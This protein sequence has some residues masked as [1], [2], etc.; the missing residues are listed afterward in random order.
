MVQDTPP[1]NG[2]S[3]EPKHLRL[4]L[5]TL[6]AYLDDVLEPAQAREIGTKIQETQYASQLVERIQDVLRRRR[7]EAPE[8]TGP[9]A[10]LDP[11]TVA[12]YLDNTLPVK[13]IADVERVCLESDTHLAEV[14]ACHQIL[15]LVLGGPIHVS[16]D[17]RARLHAL[18]PSALAHQTQPEHAASPASAGSSKSPESSSSKTQKSSKLAQESAASASVAKSTIAGDEVQPSPNG[19]LAEAA[20]GTSRLA[21]RMP[22][23]PQTKP[24]WKRALVPTCIGLVLLIWVGSLIYDPS[25][26][27]SGPKE[28]A[29]SDQK[30]TP[31]A[32]TEQK[33][34]GKT[35]PPEKT[36]VTPAETKPKP[37]IPAEGKTPEEKKPSQEVVSTDSAGN[38]ATPKPAEVPEKTGPVRAR[39][40]ATTPPRRH[41]GTN[42]P[43]GSRRECAL[44]EQRCQP[45]H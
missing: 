19:N 13:S 39:A 27:G 45:H 42:R 26:A 40:F 18:I 3:E 44:H 10:G 32:K 17:S 24:L 6:L 12:E 11:N 33:P 20:A 9:A 29:Q 30:S 16:A 35:Q 41:G 37:E 8:L 5:R 15:T 4:T 31:P 14:A 34:A 43:S 36:K 2:N 38:N 1:S 7:I 21:G 28:L 25:L 23:F 22:D